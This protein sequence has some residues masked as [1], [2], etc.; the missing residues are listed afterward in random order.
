MKSTSKI[1]TLL[2][3]ALW[4]FSCTHEDPVDVESSKAV[5]MPDQEIWDSEV[6]IT[7]KGNLEAII[8]FG[9]MSRYIK[10]S[11]TLFDQGVDIDFYKE[12]G[13]V[14]SELTSEAGEY[15]EDTK[16]VKAIGNVVVESDSGFT[17]YTQELYYYQDSDKIMSNVDVMVSTRDGDTL[18]GKGFESDAQMNFWEIKE[19]YDGVAHKGVDLSLD[20][21][22][23]KE[24]QDSA[25]IYSTSIADS[26]NVTDSADVE[27]P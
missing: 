6:K 24:K 13:E 25:L 23:K 17:L 18:Y 22:Q 12:D 9:H 27:Q 11:L 20:R 14:G 1:L 15:D 21:F 7:N 26:L 3:A 19:P 5:E 16:N 4:L 2:A 8:H 10:K